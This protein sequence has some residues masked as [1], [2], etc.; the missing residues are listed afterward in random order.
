MTTTQRGVIAELED[1]SGLTAV[2][3]PRLKQQK[4][5]VV[6]SLSDG[7]VLKVDTQAGTDYVFLSS[8]RFAFEADGVSFEGTAGAVQRRKARLVLSLGAG[9]R[10]T[11]KGETLEARKPA[12]RVVRKE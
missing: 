6:T 8:E 11:A 3:Y 4:P 7:R 1:G 9:G 2:V 5:P 12:S 10:M